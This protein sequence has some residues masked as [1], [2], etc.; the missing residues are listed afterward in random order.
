MHFTTLTTLLLP[1]LLSSVL[2][3][4][5]ATKRQDV[6]PDSSGPVE[7]CAASGMS[8]DECY[9]KEGWQSEEEAQEEGKDPELEQFDSNS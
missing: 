4:P 8:P 9:V 7:S 6:Y 1:L 5:T 3:A 2:A